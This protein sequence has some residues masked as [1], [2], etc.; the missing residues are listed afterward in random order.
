MPD[1]L[2]FPTVGTAVSGYLQATG[3]SWTDWEEDARPG[4]PPAELA[5]DPSALRRTG[6]APYLAARTAAMIAGRIV[7][8][9]P[10]TA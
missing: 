7:W 6:I 5:I 2:I 8:R 1:E 10:M 9:S 4:Q 3:Q